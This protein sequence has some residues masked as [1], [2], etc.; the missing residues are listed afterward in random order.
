M[1]GRKPYVAGAKRLLQADGQ[2]V[3]I[4]A[5][6]QRDA[7]GRAYRRIGVSLQELH[8]F[9]GEPVDVRS[10][11]IRTA[12]AREIGITEIVGED[13]Q[14]VG[15][16]RRCASRLRPASRARGV[17]A[18]PASTCRRVGRNEWFNRSSFYILLEDKFH[19][20]L[21]NPRIECARNSA[22]TAG[23]A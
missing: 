9:R 13:E 5:R 6:D 4:T 10:G 14:D 18:V 15:R 23:S 7:A 20:E 3:L 11:V 1:F 2:S 19:R 16:G 17:A 21:Q 8:A 12:I 22:E